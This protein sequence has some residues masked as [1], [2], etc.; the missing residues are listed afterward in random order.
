[1]NKKQQLLTALISEI[2][3]PKPKIQQIISGLTELETETKKD[4]SHCQH[5]K[6]AEQIKQLNQ[7]K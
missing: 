2:N 5:Q 7:G 1:M 6:Y 3:K 4:C